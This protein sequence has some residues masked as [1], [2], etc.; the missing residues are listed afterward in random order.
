MSNQEERRHKQQYEHYGVK[1][2]LSFHHVLS[3]LHKHDVTQEYRQRISQGCQQNDHGQC[4]QERSACNERRP[5]ATAGST[6]AG[7]IYPQHAIGLL[8]GNLCKRIRYKLMHEIQ[9]YLT[10]E[11]RDPFK[12]WLASLTDQMVKARI[13]A[14]VQRLAAGTSAIANH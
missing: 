4:C 2:E 1:D 13:A 7:V 14:R 11:G 3:V 6:D 10:P 12:D 9:D 5:F 8:A